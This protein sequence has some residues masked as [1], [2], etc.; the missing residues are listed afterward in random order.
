MSADCQCLE[1]G[2]RHPDVSTERDLG[3][4]ETEG[5]Y[6]EVDLIRCT[7]CA[8]IWLRYSLEYEHVSRSGRWAEAP[9]DAVAAATI[10]AETAS[11]FID[12]AEWYVFGG[13][14]YGHAGK[15]GSGRLRWSY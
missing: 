3:H 10:R 9:I 4:D 6:A 12:A 14:Y 15:R 11:A 7:R 13:S 1:R 2:P 5:R 8:R